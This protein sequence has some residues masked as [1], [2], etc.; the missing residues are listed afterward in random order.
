MARLL[1]TEYG[2]DVN[3]KDNDGLAPLHWAV[4][5]RQVE[6]VKLLMT[7]FG[8]DVNIENKNGRTPL[9]CVASPRPRRDHRA[10]G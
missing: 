9:H 3:V 2:V 7:E 5:R 8:A 4:N 10:V 6:I 1:L